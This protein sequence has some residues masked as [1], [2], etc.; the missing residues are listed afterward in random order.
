VVSA[1][2]VDALTGMTVKPADPVAGSSVRRSTC[3]ARGRQRLGGQRLA[4]ITAARRAF[5]LNSS[6]LSVML[7]D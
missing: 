5:S 3:S 1:G 7:F 6:S 2:P 4:R